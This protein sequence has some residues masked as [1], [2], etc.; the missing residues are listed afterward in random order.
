MP[1]SPVSSLPSPKRVLIII[2]VSLGPT[3]P[4][5]RQKTATG[6]PESRHVLSWLGPSLQMLTLLSL[7]LPL[8]LS[9]SSPKSYISCINTPQRPFETP[10]SALHNG[11]PP[12][13]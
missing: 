1:V 7:C 8:G 4:F 3:I 2:P 9:T 10:S 6:S 5:A 13:H 11:Y 12:R